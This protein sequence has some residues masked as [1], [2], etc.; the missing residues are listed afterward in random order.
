MLSEKE[1]RSRY[2]PSDSAARVSAGTLLRPLC[3]RCHI[4]EFADDTVHIREVE[5]HI[6]GAK[7]KRFASRVCIKRRNRPLF[8]EVD[9]PACRNAF[10]F[11]RH[12]FRY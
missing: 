7:G 10:Y 6:H 4:G 8:C 5:V 2:V 11:D 1:A 3:C 9:S 12:F